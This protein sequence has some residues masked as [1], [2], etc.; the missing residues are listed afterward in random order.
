MPELHA[1]TATVVPGAPPAPGTLADRVDRLFAMR[2]SARSVPA[3]E[4]QVAQEIAVQGWPG[5]S[6]GWLC[7]LRS[8]RRRTARAHQL[9]AV[10]E[11]FGVPPEYFTDDA[12]AREVDAELAMWASIHRPPAP[13]VPLHRP[14]RP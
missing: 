1:Q 3:T 14:S 4:E 10:A 6:A 9:A 13:V 5:V 7:D 11:H 8:G 2:W 12:V